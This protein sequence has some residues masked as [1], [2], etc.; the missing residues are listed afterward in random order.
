MLKSKY[1]YDHMFLSLVTFD[2][3]ILKEIIYETL[4]I[5]VGYAKIINSKM[6]KRRLIER[7]NYLDLVVETDIGY[8]NIEVSNDSYNKFTAHRNFVYLTSLINNVT[9]SGM[10]L[11]DMPKVYQINLIFGKSSNV[12]ISKYNMYSKEERKELTKKLQILNVYMDKLK[13]IYYNNNKRLTGKMLLVG[14]AMTKEELEENKEENIMFEKLLK[15]LDE[16]E[17]KGL[18]PELMP[19][20]EENKWY[21]EMLI[22]SAR[23]EGLEQGI[24]QGIEQGFEQGMQKKEREFISNMLNK[25]FDFKT[26]SEITGLSLNKIKNISKNLGY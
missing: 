25:K 5:K 26:I 13:E 17:D 8:I 6:A 24:E 9:K 10:K 20:E 22:E 12:D 7:A 3:E 18:A 23:E 14:L 21:R 4:N 1:R 2:N 16:M 19:V 15:K 11:K